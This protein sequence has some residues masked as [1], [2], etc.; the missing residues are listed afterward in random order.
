MTLFRKTVVTLTGAEP[1]KVTPVALAVN[2]GLLA[3]FAA[4][5][6][7]STLG[8]T[9]AFLAMLHGSETNER[10]RSRYVRM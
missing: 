6:A 8:S 5:R 1:K 2:A 4:A 7:E 9:L 3:D 10:V